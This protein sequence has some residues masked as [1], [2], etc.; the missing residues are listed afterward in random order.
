MHDIAEILVIHIKHELNDRRLSIFIFNR[1]FL[2]KEFHFVM[3]L[4]IVEAWHAL[5]V[6]LRY[7]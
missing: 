5:F 1:K 4:K 3:S 6:M 7:R 2:L